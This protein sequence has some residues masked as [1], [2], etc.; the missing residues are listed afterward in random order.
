[1][2]NYYEM[3]KVEPSASQ[4]EVETAIDAQYNQW[5][6]LTTHHDTNVVNQ[7]NQALALIDKIRQ[8]LTDPTRR[9]VYD[10]A[11]GVRGQEIG[12]LVDPTL[13]LHQ[14]LPVPVMTP[15]T[16]KVTAAPTTATPVVRADVW[17]CP[18]CEHPNA[19]GAQFCAK[20][21]VKIGNPC[22]NCDKMTELANN[23]C[24]YCGVDKVKAY[25]DQRTGEVKVAQQEIAAQREQL[26]IYR[27]AA[28]K[29][30][31][32]GANSELHSAFTELRQGRSGCFE[33]ILFLGLLGF[34]IYQF[35]QDEPS[36]GIVLI[37]A[38]FVVVLF[39]SIFGARSTAQKNFIDKANQI[40]NTINGLEQKIKAIQAR[41]YPD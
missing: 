19:I 30:T 20:D 33:S 25:Q 37:A 32:P 13:L 12:G 7:A 14:A 22:P 21:G 23:F 9:E 26:R 16:A 27:A 6:R 8:T 28:D 2:T 3:L 18:K 17:V 31:N 34:G 11:I 35:I 36:F 41:Q 5:R 1:M 10:Q 38:S 24:P 29:L 40:N 4:H 15:P 39:A